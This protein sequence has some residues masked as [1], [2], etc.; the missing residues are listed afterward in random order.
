MEYTT[1]INIKGKDYKFNLVEDDPLRFIMTIN[2]NYDL[3][4]DI[5]CDVPFEKWTL[6]K[7]YKSVLNGVEKDDLFSDQVYHGRDI[8][9]DNFMKQ[10]LENVLF[11]TLIDEPEDIRTLN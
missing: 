9:D 1:T 2:D 3:I 7:K 6:V 8:V 10:L 5:N 4:R 11:M